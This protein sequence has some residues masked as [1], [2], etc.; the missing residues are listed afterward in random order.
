M[1]LSLIL[2]W[3][4]SEKT[5]KLKKERLGLPSAEVAAPGSASECN[6]LFFEL[7]LWCT[8]LP[9]EVL[10]NLVV[11]HLILWSVFH[12]RFSC[13]PWWRSASLELVLWDA[14]TLEGEN[15]MW[16]HLLSASVPL[17]GVSLW[18]NTL[19]RCALTVPGIGDFS[20][21]TGVGSL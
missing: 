13:L 3:C 5:G 10:S 20:W 2:W 12:C 6:H 4:S 11:G 21:G 8:S 1:G 9:I 16:W 18:W 15:R 17:A 7:P 19:T 14:A